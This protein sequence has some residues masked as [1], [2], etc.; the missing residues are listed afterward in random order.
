VLFRS[1]VRAMAFVTPVGGA[2]RDGAC[3]IVP[4]TGR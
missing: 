1:M 3:E 2:V 4:V